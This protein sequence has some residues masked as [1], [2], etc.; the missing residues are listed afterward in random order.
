MTLIRG[1]AL[2]GYVELVTERGGNTSALLLA[3]GISRNAIG[4]YGAF[5]D[6]VQM[7]RAIEGGR[8][9]HCDRRLRTASRAAAGIEIVGA[10]GAAARSAPTVAQA[11][12]TSTAAVG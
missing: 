2:T 4:A 1:T 10:V 11:L 12:R 8:A 9:Q 5:V 7:L 6:Y 3:A